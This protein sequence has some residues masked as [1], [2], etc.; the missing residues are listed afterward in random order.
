MLA[1]TFTPAS[2]AA[3]CSRQYPARRHA[4]VAVAQPARAAQRLQQ[5]RSVVAG[6]F[7]AALPGCCRT[8]MITWP[9]AWLTSAAA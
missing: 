7:A 2:G 6:A 1:L 5:G 9:N 4:M 3:I 8:S